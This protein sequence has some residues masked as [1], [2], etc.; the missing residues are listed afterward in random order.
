MSQH[1]NKNSTAIGIIGAVIILGLLAGVGGVYVMGMPSGNTSAVAG[2]V[3][4]GDGSG[5]CSAAPT[6]AET[7]RPLARGQIAAMTSVSEPVS[8]AS[9]TFNAPDGEQTSVGDMAGKLA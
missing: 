4:G 5:Q 1:N 9:L 6:L 8:L 2:N 3:S 7:I